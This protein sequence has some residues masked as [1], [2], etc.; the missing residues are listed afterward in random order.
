MEQDVL[1]HTYIHTCKACVERTNVTTDF[2][3]FS[4]QWITFRDRE[5]PKWEGFEC[6]RE[7]STLR[8][9]ERFRDSSLSIPR[10][11][12]NK[13]Q[14]FHNH[15]QKKEFSAYSHKMMWKRSRLSRVCPPHPPPR[16]GTPWLERNP[17][18]PATLPSLRTVG[19]KD[20]T[21]GWGIDQTVCFNIMKWLYAS[22]P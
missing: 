14:T 11:L 7:T 20:G 3:R 9:E 12:K 10:C 13:N 16:A 4:C 19:V 18:F 17:L 21:Q 15:I 2:L 1:L 22:S 5:A 6:T 8:R